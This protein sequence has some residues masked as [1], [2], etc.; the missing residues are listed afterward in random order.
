MWQAAAL[1]RLGR[2]A[3]TRASMWQVAALWRGLALPLITV[4]ADA[5]AQPFT[6][7]PCA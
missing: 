1:W 2:R 4:A 5:A 7:L 3:R 6:L